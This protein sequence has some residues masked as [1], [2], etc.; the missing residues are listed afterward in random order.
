MELTT[1]QIREKLGEF[2]QKWNDN[3]SGK[4]VT[5]LM[6]VFDEGILNWMNSIGALKTRGTNI[7]VVLPAFR[8]FREKEELLNRLNSIR[9]YAKNKEIEH[10]EK[11]AMTI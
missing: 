11:E 2:E 9:E 10:L 8:E 6:G 7:S 3:K 4:L 1:N 5:T